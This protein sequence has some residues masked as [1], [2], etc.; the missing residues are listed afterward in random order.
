M[1]DQLSKASIINGLKAKVEQMT[2]ANKTLSNSLMD[3]SKEVET[4]QTK[5][6]ELEANNTKLTAEL[7]T[8]RGLPA[9]EK[10]NTV[11]QDLRTRA[12]ALAQEVIKLSQTRS[13]RVTT[14]DEMAHQLKLLH[15]TCDAQE[16]TIASLKAEL[17]ETT[18]SQ[19]NVLKSI[20]AVRSETVQV[21]KTKLAE[22][23][24]SHDG[25][26]QGLSSIHAENEVLRQKLDEQSAVLATFTAKIAD[27][28]AQLAKKD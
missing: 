22:S 2:E 3:K 21:L 5:V 17:S 1:G 26:M 15:G 12:E 11:M 10:E 7:N 28:V 25:V 6:V 14:V 9:D 16:K 8:F 23:K 27:I 13:T 4:L 18:S 24:A 20:D 19:G